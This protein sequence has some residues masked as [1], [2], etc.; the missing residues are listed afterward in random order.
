MCTICTM[1]VIIN[2]DYQISFSSILLIF[3]HI[4]LQN[5]HV[6]CSHSTPRRLELTYLL[7]E[8]VGAPDFSAYVIK[9]LAVT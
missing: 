2:K 4:A 9:L 1:S 5:A 8:A 3:I 6:I 7:P